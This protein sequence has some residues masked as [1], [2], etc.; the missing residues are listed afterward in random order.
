MSPTTQRID[1]L[2][3]QCINEGALADAWAKVHSNA[4]C[5][6]VDGVGV[7]QF[8]LNAL[9]ALFELKA[10]VANGSYHPQPLLG[11]PIPKGEGRFRHLAI[12]TV[13]DRVLQTAVAQLLT[14]LIDPSF[15]DASFGYRTGRS[16]RQATT[17][18]VACREQGLS[19]VLDADIR[20]YFDTIH[21]PTLLAMLRQ[22][23]PD[24]SL[25]SLVAH[26]LA[27]PVLETGMLT[28]R[29]QG[30]AQGSPL[31]PLLANLYLHP[32]D[33]AM[34]AADFTLIRYA[35]DFLVMCR[36][37]AQA[38]AALVL[39]R[40]ELRRLRLELNEEKTRV[41]HFQAGFRFLGV[42]FEGKRA[43]PV[44][45]ETAAWVMPLEVPM[46]VATCAP[47]LSSATPA[48]RAAQPEVAVK[49]E[50]IPPLAL[51]DAAG[52][53]IAEVLAPDEVLLDDESDGQSLPR[54]LH[55]TTQGCYISREHERL[56]ISRNHESLA[57]IPFRQLDQVVIHGNAS[58]STAVIRHCRKLG[59][60]LAFADA[61]GA[62]PIA[63]D[64]TPDLN[65]SLLVAQVERRSDAAFA[66]QVARACV[67]G[68]LHNGLALLKGFSRRGQSERVCT[69][70]AIL[71]RSLRKLDQVADLDA[72]RGVEGRAA[73]SYFAAFAELL[74]EGWSFSGRNRHPPMDPVNALLSYGYA[75]LAHI[76]ETEV[77][78]GHLHAAFG[79]L[80]SPLPGRPSLA[81]D[82]ME[83]FR[84]PVV[85]ATVLTLI[86]KRSLDPVSDFSPPVRPGQGCQIS[87]AARQVLI[88][89]IEARLEA[90]VAC[91]EGEGRTPLR[92]MLRS[93]VVRYAQ[94]L[95]S[96]T[97]FEPYLSR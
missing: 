74:P 55:V 49:R 54:S 93:Q 94:A 32:L 56:L 12:P 7:E 64:T 52:E 48:Q 90:P 87:L 96:D 8:K 71:T 28:P 63:V 68:K 2:L 44:E 1:S 13:K 21:H 14:R 37:R 50:E 36:S 65:Q 38:E 67:R 75:M 30:V 78:L 29:R 10:E 77:W 60:A 41:T 97:P 22:R 59:I 23:L 25:T 85:D 95:T 15:D 89:R 31:S 33:C 46:A 19:W 76:V 40:S 6:G 83:A 39:T 53:D 66:I 9:T 69:A 3:M 62:M 17:R 88:A 11:V 18:I 43:T 58:I 80:H 4:G 34:G 86:R 92:R 72:L 26:W 81:C 84:A 51:A 35:D 70:M 20:D 61:R 47:A 79:H 5:A 91:A 57:K 45:P 42:R 27:A 82:L 24:D 73:R 16:V